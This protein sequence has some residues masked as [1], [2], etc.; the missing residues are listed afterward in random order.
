MTLPKKGTRKITVNDESYRW[1][2]RRKATY[3]QTDYGIGTLHV[4]VEH[5]QKPGST[6]VI[7]TDRSHP[8][9]YSTQKTQIQPVTPADVKEW[10]QKAIEQGWQPKTPGSTFKVSVKGDCFIAAI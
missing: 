3:G 2:I 7:I 4:A 9:D 5:F 1:L 8:K 10:I 6:L